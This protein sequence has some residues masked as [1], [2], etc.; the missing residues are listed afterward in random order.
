M[1]G[2]ISAASASVCIACGIGR[3]EVSRES[4]VKC[5]VDSYIGTEA[6]IACESC[7]VGRSTRTLTGFISCIDD[8]DESEKVLLLEEKQVLLEEKTTLIKDNTTCNGEKATL[9]GE[10]EVL[11][12]EKEQVKREKILCIEDNTTLTEERNQLQKDKKELEKKLKELQ[13]K[14]AKLVLT[15]SDESGSGSSDSSGSSGS[16]GSN[17]NTTT[18]TTI[19]S[20]QI[21]LSQT[22]STMITSNCISGGFILLLLFI[23][24]CHPSWVVK[25]CGSTRSQKQKTQSNLLI[26]SSP[27]NKVT[28][29]A[30]IQTKT[31]P[32]SN[33]N[34][35]KM[36]Q[37]I[38]R[39]AIHYERAMSNMDKGVK[40]LKVHAKKTDE[41]RKSSSARLQARKHQRVK[42]KRE[43][44]G[45]GTIVNY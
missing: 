6:K 43:L 38:S 13:G 36:F 24:C 23:M 4:C 18:T 1:P 27:Q 9:L 35:V 32:R 19:A 17:T 41:R 16:S 10:L 11:N 33:S 44:G 28:P 31:L 22:Q 30:T 34:K 42:S 25:V 21:K 2:F 12:L 39:N 29:L 8:C 40:S 7:A 37:D 5:D 26:D 15:S 45:E 20:L 14:L 3:I